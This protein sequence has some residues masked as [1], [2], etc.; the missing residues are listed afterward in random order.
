[1]AEGED[2]GVPKLEMLDGSRGGGGERFREVCCDATGEG[3]LN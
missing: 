2:R 1:M 3:P